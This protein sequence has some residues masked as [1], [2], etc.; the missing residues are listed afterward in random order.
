MRSTALRRVFSSSGSGSIP[1]IYLPSRPSPCP[2]KWP[3]GGVKRG[4]LSPSLRLHW[5]LTTV[6]PPHAPRFTPHALSTTSVNR[7]GPPPMPR[8]ELGIH[9]L[10]RWLVKCLDLVE[11]RGVHAARNGPSKDRKCWQ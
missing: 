8:A 9:G 1:Y 3:N 5:P 2:V 4:V 10:N 11:K 7:R 6:L